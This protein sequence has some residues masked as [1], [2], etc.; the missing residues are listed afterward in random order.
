MDEK[1][2]MADMEAKAEKAYDAM[3]DAASHNVKDCCEDACLF[4]AEAITIANKLGL[5]EE[6]ARLAA[7]KDHIRAVYN[8]QFR[9]VG[10]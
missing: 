6:A 2:R 1:D 3:Y 5:A 7:R 9:Y 4:L 10:R 8:S